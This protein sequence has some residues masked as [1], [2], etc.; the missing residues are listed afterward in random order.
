MRKV[1]QILMLAALVLLSG[2]MYAQGTVKGV[3]LDNDTKEALL[4]ATA[5][6]EGTT[7][8]TT[9]AIDGSF[10]FSAPA[11][12]HVLLI[13]FI[14]YEEINMDVTV[15]DG[16]ITDLGKIFVKSTSIG[17]DEVK[18]IASVAVDRKTPVAVSTVKSKTIE[19]RLGGR[20]LPQILEF[21]PSLYASPNGGGYGDSRVNIRGFNQRNV[22]VLINGIP[23]NDMEN[24]WVYW[25]NWAGL[26]DATSQIQVQRGLGASKLA[27]N[28]VGGTMNIITKTTDAEKGGS[29][30]YEVTDFGNQ[31]MT[32][33]LS[34][35][36]M[37]TG[38][39]VYFVGSRTWGEGYIPATYV[40]AWSYYLSVSQDIGKKHK[41]TFTA[42]GAPQ[43]HGQRYSYLSKEDFDRWGNKYNGDWGWRGGEQLNQRQ[44]YYHKPQFALN[45]YYDIN[46]DMFLATSA[47]I[48]TGN[49]GGSG[50]LGKYT[51]RTAL[52]LIDWDQ[53]V[54]WNSNNM[55]INDTVVNTDGDTLSESQSILRNSVNN[56]FW[57]GILSTLKIDLSDNFNLMVGIDGRSYKGEHYREV[58][59]L[60]GGD[61][62]Y[63]KYKYAVDGVAGRNQIMKVGDKI[64]YDNDG[65][66]RY[67][68]AF[69]QLEYTSGNFSAFVAGT[70]S[71]TWFK[72]I[73]RYNYVNEADQESELLNAVGYNGKLGANYNINEQHNIFAN[74]GYYSK[75]PDFN[76]LWPNY[77][78]EKS[79]DE[80]LNEKIIGF[81]L[82]YGFKSRFFHANVNGYYTMWQDKSLLSRSFSSDGQ[83][84]RSFITGLD[85]THMGIEAEAMAHIT[86]VFDI[87]ILAA[88]GNWE[89]TNDVI[90]IVVDDQTFQI[91]ST[92]VYAE[93][94]K[95]GDAPQ[96]QLGLKLQYNP[97]R[98][99]NL[100]TDIIYYDH[101]Y[102]DF[103]PA[104]R[105]NP[106]DREQAYKVPS[107]TMVNFYAAYNFKLAGLNSQF[108]ANVF[109]V[110]D[111]E[112][113]AEAQDGSNHDEESVVGF[114]GF[115]RTFNFGWKI[116]F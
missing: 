84:T 79:T 64:A 103:D 57:Y 108:T 39:A 41:L 4:G 61:F 59:D 94:L 43:K 53:A 22:A 99:I 63:E 72:R 96:T 44:N 100:G 17:L 83:D 10:S 97:F 27:I 55:G 9:A 49:G 2:A 70:L 87:G 40:D 91:D 101:F 46:E 67:G 75:A 73:D 78:N 110:F 77:T 19:E 112:Y 107:W 15:I 60:M 114:Y 35:G 80:I 88:I 115:G 69:A 92:E 58:R 65:L 76:F 47:Y 5:A 68:G 45:W 81:E 93:G 86:D 26:G 71:N 11:G 56:H 51:N 82:G 62:Y 24:G 8:G 42:I 95:V 14:G 34:T 37:S 3:I 74:F 109:N 20:D 13:R 29:F 116:F 38:T 36:K 25:S 16:K 89:W 7:I 52:G 28:S 113:W 6:I 21:T 48:S 50:P 104:D 31:K 1:Y 12:T 66:V 23:V 85:A 54:A 98:K 33:S 90:G 30:K 106:A 105:D 18:V 102:A 111:V 32:L